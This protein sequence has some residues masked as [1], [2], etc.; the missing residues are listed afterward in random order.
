MQFDIVMDETDGQLTFILENS[1]YKNEISIG[2][3][4]F[5]KQLFHDGSFDEF[6]EALELRTN[7]TLKIADCNMESI[8]NIFVISD[9]KFKII[10]GVYTDFSGFCGTEPNLHGVHHFDNTLVI[11]L[12][13]DDNANK[14]LNVFSILKTFQPKIDEN[15]LEGEDINSCSD[16]TDENNDY[17]NLGRITTI[18]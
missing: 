12:N 2:T 18:M 8:K 11:P 17:D 9:S 16:E 15:E 1:G 5:R 6:I 10:S 3:S 4:I 13:S 14:L 7:Y